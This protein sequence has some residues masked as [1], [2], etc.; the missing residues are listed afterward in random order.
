MELANS[1]TYNYLFLTLLIPLKIFS[2]SAFVGKS[3][4]KQ[5][6]FSE[7]TALYINKC[8]KIIN[9]SIFTTNK[10]KPN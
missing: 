5:L 4:E 8:S 10:T 2:K 3:L 7:N 6:K 1:E 9:L